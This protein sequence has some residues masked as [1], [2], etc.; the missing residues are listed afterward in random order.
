MKIKG[1]GTE[2]FVP[3]PDEG[4]GVAPLPIYRPGQE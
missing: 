4:L 1:V 2:E 3:S